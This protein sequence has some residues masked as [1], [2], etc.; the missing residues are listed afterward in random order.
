MKD[1]DSTTNID[2]LITIYNSEILK[3]KK[4]MVTFALKA[5]VANFAT[6][7]KDG[8]TYQRVIEDL[9]ELLTKNDN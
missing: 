2:K 5:V 7:D 9:T 3:N 4:S 1:K 8:K 6:T